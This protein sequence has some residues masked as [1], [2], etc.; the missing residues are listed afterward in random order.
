MRCGVPLCAAVRHFDLTAARRQG[1]NSSPAR[2][3]PTLLVWAR[4]GAAALQVFV[5]PCALP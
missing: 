2:L 4:P 5:L 1:C 3:L